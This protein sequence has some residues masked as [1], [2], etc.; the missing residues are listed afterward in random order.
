MSDIQTKSYVGKTIMNFSPR[1]SSNCIS[2]QNL[3]HGCAQT[4]QSFPKSRHFLSIF[5]KDR[6][7]D[8]DHRSSPSG[9]AS[10]GPG[11]VSQQMYSTTAVAFQWS[12]TS[13]QHF[14]GLVRFHGLAYVYRLR[15]ASLIKPT[16]TRCTVQKP[17]AGC[18][19]VNKQ[20]GQTLLD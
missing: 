5:K 12:V 11:C 3:T 2:K 9:T 1:C 7:T 10:H 19:F 16:A 15:N 17:D 14:L 8:D 18:Q 20:Q 4:G 13:F 6:E